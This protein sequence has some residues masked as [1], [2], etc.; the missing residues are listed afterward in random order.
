M[1]KQI[2]SHDLNNIMENAQQKLIDAQKE[3]F[4]VKDIVTN[5]L[6]I[7]E[8]EKLW[9]QKCLNDLSSINKSSYLSV[10]LY[11]NAEGEFS[12]YFLDVLP[13]LVKTPINVF[14]II[15][16]QTVFFREDV[17]LFLLKQDDE[18]ED[19]TDIL[20]HD[21]LKNTYFFRRFNEK[22][23]TFILD[24]KDYQYP[25][26]ASRFNMIEIDAFLPGS[27]KLK[28]IELSYG[29][30]KIV[31]N[32]FNRIGKNRILLDEKKQIQK[33]EFCFEILYSVKNGDKVYYPFGLKHIY[34]YDA[35][36]KKDSHVIV[37]IKS[38]RLI[39][40]IQDECI[41]SSNRGVQET[42]LKQMN[43]EIYAHYADN[44]LYMPVA[45]SNPYEIYELPLQ[46]D[47]LYA[48]IP[49]QKALSQIGF[50]IK[51]K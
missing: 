43:I 45:I 47:T 9:N 50:K 18:K 13:A 41:I 48:K 34:L 1:I 12:T 23:V 15:S 42:T 40:I 19:V 36:F 3:L 32:D 27:F 46:T 44:Q 14:N 35:D 28:S 17:N 25:L 24:V 5:H 21:S 33:I 2:S 20:K 37:K 6:D 22:D 30:E 26:G 39:N 38:D 51:N 31:Y 7:L 4:L 10:P 16:T 49:I 8:E 11:D 29:D